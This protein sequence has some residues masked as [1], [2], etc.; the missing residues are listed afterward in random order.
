MS[1]SSLALTSALAIA[2]TLGSTPAG[3][4]TASGPT[5]SQSG[6][7]YPARIL[8]NGQSACGSGTAIGS[9]TS[10]RPLNLNP[11]GV[12]YADCIA[13]MT[14]Q[15]SV[16][17][18]G[19]AGSDSLEVWASL[20]S[21]C[22]DNTDRGIGATAAVC[23]GVRA[24]NITNPVINTP[25][26][27][28]FN[29]RVQDLVGWQQSPPIPSQA[30]VPMAQGPSACNAQASFAAVPMNINFLAIDG[31]G[32]SDGTPYQ[33]NITT[34]MVGP[35]A[36]SGVSETVGDT[37][38]NVTWTANSDSD[39]TGYD[40]LIDP[41]PGQEF[42]EAGT[43]LEGGQKLI[44]PDTGAGPIFDAT[45]FDELETPIEASVSD[46][47]VPEAAP[48]PYDGGC[49]L[50]NTGGVPP[51]SAAGFNCNDPILAGALLEDGGTDAQTVI[52][53]V[54]DEAGDLIE[55]GTVEEG[56]GGISTI[57]AQYIYNPQ[58]GFTI[59]DKAVGKYTIKGLVDGVT[60]TVV[61]ASVDGTGNVGPPSPEV[62][63]YPAPVK[64][65]WQV[66]EQDGGG[67]GGFCALESIG[68]GGE[69]LA[70]VGIVLGIAAIARRRRR[71]TRK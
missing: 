3:A 53:P 71:S 60:Y 20:T 29:I 66:Y 12:S 55:G 67:A 48:L 30:E 34:D 68:A 40:I 8:P 54:E 18:N 50:I 36:P 15:F 42:G 47:N 38:Y 10:T 31:D 49:Y 28:T 11:F 57:P 24:A 39:T 23:W 43:S 6:Q 63:D 45:G 65:F 21:P 62:C 22:T 4:Q 7:L 61:V 33:Y 51:T 64:D 1:R 17:L 9:C 59:P 26:T 52:Q 46:A 27:Y 41:I 5:I 56:V 19:F 58:A 2:A 25:Q 14:L 69:S 37:I 70:G 35:P 44:C 13:D 32:N 16:T